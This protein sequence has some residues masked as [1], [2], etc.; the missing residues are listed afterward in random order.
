MLKNKVFFF[1]FLLLSTQLHAQF[2][3]S[4]RVTDASTG[5]HLQGA[6]VVLQGHNRAA[7]T[8]ALGEFQLKKVPRGNYTLNISYIGYQ[9][10]TQPIQFEANQ[11]VEVALQTATGM[12]EEV[13]VSATRVTQAIPSAFT[14]IPKRDIEKLNTGRDLPY[15]L[16]QTPSVLVTSDAGTGVGYTSLRIR[17]T[18]ISRINVMINGIPLNDPESQIVYWVDLPDFASSTDNIQ[19]QRGVGTSVNG[20]GAFGASINLQT[21]Q[22]PA[23]A[24]ARIH[25]SGGS[26]NTLR[27][28]VSFATGRNQGRFALE[29]RLS[30]IVSDGYIDRASAGLKSFFLS[31]GYFGNNSLM[32]INVFS[33]KEITYQAWEGV[34][35]ELLDSRRTFNPAGLYTNQAGDTLYYANQVDD[36]QQDH[37]QLFYSLAPMPGLTLNLAGHYTRGGGY[38]ESYKQRQKFSEYG[39]PD[40]TIGGD[41]LKRTDLIRRKHLDND[42]IG[43]TFSAIYEPSENWKLIAGAGYHYFKGWHFGNIIW[44]RYASA[45]FIDEDYYR[46]SGIKKD[47]NTYLKAIW[48]P[49]KILSFFGDIQYRHVDY[50]MAGTHDDLRLLDQK[51][52]FRFFNPK[53]GLQFAFNERQRLYM[54]LAVANR[55]PSRS[56][57]R[58]ADPG[59]QPRKE[60][61]TD[62]ELGYEWKSN[63]MQ[64]AANAYWM[65]YRDQLVLTGK[66]NNVGSPVMVNIPDSYRA[67]LELQAGLQLFPR[68]KLNGHLTLSRNRIKGF[69]EYLDNWDTGGQ[70]SLFYASTDISFSPSVIAGMVLV[71]NPTARAGLR[72]GSKYAGRQFIDNTSDN[73]RSLDPWFITDLRADYSLSLPY[74][75]S[76]NFFI[77]V[78]NLFNHRYES[79]AWVYSYL[80]EGN[81]GK[82]DGYFPQAGINFMAG[83]EIL[84]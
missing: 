42:F 10:F 50:E 43:G 67:G 40:I 39:L 4:G 6:H 56:D 51:H 22:M 7:I 25:M 84:L 49:G 16:E 44:A 47:L 81:R 77:A 18:D 27:N 69:T 48:M 28:S 17:G 26:F 58:D 54:S 13:V 83:L 45:G 70:D 8:G 62:Y 24:E 52:H 5:Q 29:G 79:N 36:Y 3:L 23:E 9:L 55:E 66:I 41:T 68:L 21:S 46:N 72:L 75:R 59:R 14:D 12:Q 61:L 11:W 63:Q 30:R 2:S 71:W 60:K 76:V 32:R 34:P 80:Y 38:Y 37:F 53:A 31:A 1:L 20:A 19:V 33:G 73:G 15:L 35:S 78:N 57:F 82:I 64:F 74:T 65:Q